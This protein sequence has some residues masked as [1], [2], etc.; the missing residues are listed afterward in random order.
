MEKTSNKIILITLSLL[1]AG[2]LILSACSLLPG[3]TSDEP[4]PTPEPVIAEETGVVA[5]GNIVPRDTARLAFAVSGEVSEVLVEEGDLV[6]KGDVLARLGDTES[7]QANLAAAELELLHTQQQLDT[8]NEQ[9]RLATEQANYAVTE[10]ENNLLQAQQTLADLD[11]DDYQQ[12]ID[13]A[14]EAVNTAEEDL[15]DA[16]D[17]FNKVKDL[18]EDNNTRQNAEQNL[19]DAQREYD[20]AVR[21][22]DVL[23]N[24]LEQARAA[25]PLAEAR[26]EDA[27]RQADDRQAGPDPDEL[28]LAVE[29]VTTAEAGVTAAQ[30]ALS[31]LELVA[32]FDGTL[33][34]LVITPGELVAPNQLV[35]QIADLSQWY[36]ETSDLT[37]NEV[38]KIS[39]GQKLT[40]TPDALPD[41]TLDGVV[42][43]IGD[44]FLEKSGDITY[45]VRILLDEADPRLKWGMTVEIEFKE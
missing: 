34:D 36:V 18:D 12:E 5:E 9:A 38:V 33:V 11:T 44:S 17:E 40:V 42:E 43:S 26:L 19:E 31:K 20:Q 6:A 13:D 41:L 14:V 8:L 2:S 30:A 22:R 3:G 21:D 23:L 28:A 29:A 45:L 1:L 39:A 32:P 4:T 7:L 27:Q 37:E 16:Q 35:G 24:R 10:A 15:T 25:V